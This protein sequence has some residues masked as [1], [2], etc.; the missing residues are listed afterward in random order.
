MITCPTPR[1]SWAIFQRASFHHETECHCTHPTLWLN[2]YDQNLIS[3]STQSLVIPWFILRL[4]ETPQWHPR[5]LFSVEDGIILLRTLG[6]YAEIL[7]I[8]ACWRPHTKS[9]PVPE[10]SKVLCIT[11]IAQFC[12]SAWISY[13]TPY[14]SVPHSK[15]APSR[16]QEIY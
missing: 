13:S 4:W 12:T 1:P 3:S 2:G 11:Y 15:L 16:T 5:S 14:F 7:L 10:I 8:G 6:I 9:L